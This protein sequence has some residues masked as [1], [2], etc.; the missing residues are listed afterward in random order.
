MFLEN[1]LLMQ[2][3]MLTDSLVWA[4]WWW[5]GFC[6]MCGVWGGFLSLASA[7]VFSA[8]LVGPGGPKQYCLQLVI[9]I[10]IFIIW[11]W[12]VADITRALSG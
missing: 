5:L 4:L 11:L 3:R 10:H 12:L 2:L 6:Q 7:L 8:A 9:Y 1:R